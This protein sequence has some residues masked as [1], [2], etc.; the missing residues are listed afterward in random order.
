MI[1]KVSFT[2]LA[3]NPDTW[4][5]EVT[6]RIDAKESLV[7]IQVDQ[8]NRGRRS[9]RLIEGGAGWFVRYA[10]NLS[11]MA[12]LFGPA[13]KKQCL[14]FGTRWANE[15]PTNREFFALKTQL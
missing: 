7:D 5:Q 13:T 3:G 12:I 15:D 8:H 6:R 1:N 2:L 4:D 9:A 11:D 10:S 14:D